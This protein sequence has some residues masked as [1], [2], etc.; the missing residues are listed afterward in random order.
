MQI[1]IPVHYFKIIGIGHLIVNPTQVILK[2]IQKRTFSY[3]HYSLV[4]IS[5]MAPNN[6]LCIKYVIYTCVRQICEI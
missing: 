6:I 3:I 4:K 5:T 1:Y 2:N